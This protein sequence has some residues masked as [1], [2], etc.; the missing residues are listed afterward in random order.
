RGVGRSRQ[1]TSIRHRVG[2]RPAGAHG[3]AARALSPHAGGNG[4]DERRRRARAEPVRV[5]GRYAMNARL[6]AAPLR[7]AWRLGVCTLLLTAPCALNAQTTLSDARDVLA[8]L[9]EAYGPSGHEGPVREQ[10]LRMLPGWARP[11]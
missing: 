5:P 6:R 9:V 4:G 7:T 1:R 2:R 10:V 3:A 8:P 11:A